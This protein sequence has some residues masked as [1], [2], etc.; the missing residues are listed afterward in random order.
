MK[1]GIDPDYTVAARQGTF[2]ELGQPTTVAVAAAESEMGVA[3]AAA[4]PGGDEF[5]FEQLGDLKAEMRVHTFE[6][7]G[8][9]RADASEQLGDLNA[10]MDTVAAVKPGT[11]VREMDMTVAAK[12]FAVAHQDHYISKSIAAD[13]PTG[14]TRSTS[15]SRAR[16]RPTRARTPPA[17]RSRLA[18]S[19]ASGLTTRCTLRILPAAAFGTSFFI[20]RAD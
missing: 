2:Q 9:M 14:S 12:I 10:E 4:P 11:G 5:T 8:E 19:H 7:L 20:R 1:G 3:Q 16:P 17:P 13:V 6:K 15:R 18:P